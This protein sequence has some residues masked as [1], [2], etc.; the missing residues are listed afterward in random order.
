MS[1]EELI[2]IVELIMN[3]GYDEQNDKQL[4]ESE[5]DKLVKTFTA[6]TTCPYGSDLIFW[7]NLCNLPDG[8]TAAEI[9]D[10]ALNY[11]KTTSIS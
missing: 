4:T 10:F 5:V 9:V 7:P 3:G 11:Q 6:N 8:M 1:R 2:R